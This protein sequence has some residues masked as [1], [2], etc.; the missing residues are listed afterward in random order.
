M[1]LLLNDWHINARFSF[2]PLNDRT[3]G[4][5]ASHSVVI[6]TRTVSQRYDPIVPLLSHDFFEILINAYVP[7]VVAWLAMQYRE[8]LQCA[9]RGFRAWRHWNRRECDGWERR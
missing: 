9:W 5:L 2:H 8:R 4:K 7:R 6:C 3:H 1:W